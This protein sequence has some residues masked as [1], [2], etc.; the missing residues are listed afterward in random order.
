[1]RHTQCLKIRNVENG[2]LTLPKVAATPSAYPV[3]SGIKLKTKIYAQVK[4]EP[5]TMLLYLHL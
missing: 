3:M 4:I 2:V 1:M 5:M